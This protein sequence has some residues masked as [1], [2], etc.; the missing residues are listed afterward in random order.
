VS[1]DAFDALRGFKDLMEKAPPHMTIMSSEDVP[2]GLWRQ[3][4]T[5]GS[6]RVWVPRRVI[7]RLPRTADRMTA[8]W[9]VPVVN[10]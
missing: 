6:L 7:D 2:H 1:W 9:G 3:W 5:D 10:A 8:M 4:M